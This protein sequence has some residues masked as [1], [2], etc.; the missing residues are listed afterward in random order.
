LQ[1]DIVWSF[2]FSSAVLV[3]DFLGQANCIGNHP[4]GDVSPSTKYVEF[5][6]FVASEVRI[7]VDSFMGSSDI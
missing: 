1:G 4:T 2:V 7:A 5:S 6:S 3:D